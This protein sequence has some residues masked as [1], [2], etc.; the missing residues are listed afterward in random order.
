MSA[1]TAPLTS[2]E[3]LVAS[4]LTYWVQKALDGLG[5]KEDSDGNRWS[6]LSASDLRDRLLRRFYTDLTEHSLYRVLRSLVAKGWFVRAQLLYS[7]HRNS[8]YFYRFGPNHPDAHGGTQVPLPTCLPEAPRPVQQGD[9]RGVTEVETA[10]EQERQQGVSVLYTPSICSKGLTKNPSK[11]LSKAA[12]AAKAV[13]RTT[14]SGK[15]ATQQPAAGP[16]DREDSCATPQVP[17]QGAPAPLPQVEP[18]RP[19]QGRTDLPGVPQAPFQSVQQRILALVARF[20]P[21]S[22]TPVSPSAVVL[23]GKVHRVDDGACSPLR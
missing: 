13:K 9:S 18:T 10:A 15:P 8:T 4:Q 16:L 7:T 21:A 17:S 1:A 6:W 12:D 3:A 19:L 20:D 14:S 5:G 2:T 22:L 23:N 11:G